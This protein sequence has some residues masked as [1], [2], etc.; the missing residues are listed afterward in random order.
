MLRAGFEPAQNLSSDFVEWS[1]AV[2]IT[3]APQRNW[4]TQYH[5]KQ[6]NRNHLQKKHLECVKM[7]RND[8]KF[9]VGKYH[10]NTMEFIK[11]FPVN[12]FMPVTKFPSL[13]ILLF[14]K[15]K[16]FR[17]FGQFRGLFKETSSKNWVFCIEKKRE[18]K[19]GMVKVTKSCHQVT[20]AQES[21]TKRWDS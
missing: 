11:S 14:C 8:S 7:G 2:V 15:K 9:T 3:T 13:T 17:I 10:M 5:I 19:T 21:V 4:H 12:I 6:S 1:C 16:P 18:R 20:W